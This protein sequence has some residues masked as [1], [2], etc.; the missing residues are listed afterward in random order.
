MF[1]KNG[2]LKSKVVYKNNKP[3]TN[4]IYYNEQG[5]KEREDIYKN[6]K[7]FYEKHFD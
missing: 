7:F 5:K 3:V 2:S 4:W 1:F 6:G